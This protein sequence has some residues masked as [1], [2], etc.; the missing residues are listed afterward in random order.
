MLLWLCNASVDQFHK[1]IHYEGFF[2]E[3]I[4]F[5]PLSLKDEDKDVRWKARELWE[6]VGHK[7]EEENVDQLKQEIDFD[8]AITDYPPGGEH[9]FAESS[10]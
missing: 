1:L 3:V 8:V 2:E 4:H 6:Q 5:F 7:Y 9:L 10:L